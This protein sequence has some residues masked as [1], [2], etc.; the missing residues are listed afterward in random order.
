MG[1]AGAA[2]AA[3]VLGMSSPSSAARTG[4]HGATAS[5]GRPGDA[6]TSGLRVAGRDHANH[7]K[8]R[9]TRP[10]R[11]LLDHTFPGQST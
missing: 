2:A 7:V 5:R 11:H 10:V 6:R 8:C 3:M 1:A 4:T 9:S